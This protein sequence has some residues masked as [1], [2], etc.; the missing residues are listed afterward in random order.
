MQRLKLG[1]EIE[2]PAGTTGIRT[3]MSD[4]TMATGNEVALIR[5]ASGRRILRMGG[6]DHVTLS[7][8]DKRI[9]AHTHPSRR[10]KLSDADTR[11]ILKHNP[12]Q[13]SSVIIDALAD[14][15]VRIPLLKG[16]P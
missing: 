9:I 5:T 6:P 1:A 10:L 2:V 3:M 8:F 4:I 12:K 14:M 7:K 11:S 13:R 16:N 15:G